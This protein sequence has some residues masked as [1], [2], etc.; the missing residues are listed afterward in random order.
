[1]WGGVGAGVVVGDILAWR[2]K[3]DDDKCRK[4]HN[5]CCQRP[6]NNGYWQRDNI[7]DHPSKITE[8]KDVA[9]DTAS[10]GGGIEGNT[11]DAWY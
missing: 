9:D 7:P 6:R 2:G 10:E 5:P 1:M 11:P 4:T 3:E 8:Q